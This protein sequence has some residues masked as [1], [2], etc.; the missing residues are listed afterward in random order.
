M[1]FNIEKIFYYYK[2]HYNNNQFINQFEN[3]FREILKQNMQKIFEIE[4]KTKEHIQSILDY[5]D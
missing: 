3:Q 2:D 4:I 1:S 5:F